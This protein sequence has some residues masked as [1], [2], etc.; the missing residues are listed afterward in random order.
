MS[1]QDN[2][3][4]DYEKINDQLERLDSEI[5]QP[6]QFNASKKSFFNVKKLIVM[7]FLAITIGSVF[8]FNSSSSSSSIGG[9]SGKKNVTGKFMT[10]VP[11]DESKPICPI[12]SKVA[13]KEK[14]QVQFILYDEKY[15]EGVIER[16]SKSLQ[17]DT[18]VYDKT[19][20]YSKM[21]K[22]HEF[23]EGA[24]PLIYKTAEVFKVNSYG[25]VFHFPGSNADLKPV[26]IA[27]HM[28]TVPIGDPHDWNEDP[29]S[30]RFDGDKFHGRGASDCKNLLIGIMEA[31]EKLIQDG[32][33]NFERGV[34]LAFGFDEE[35]SGFDGAFH[36]GEFLVN[37]FGENSVEVITDEGPVMFIDTLGDYYSMIVNGE[38]GYAD[39]EVEITTPGGHSSNPRDH[40][41]IG[42]ISKFL[43]D[44]EDDLYKPVLSD[45]SPMVGFFECLGEHGRLPTDLKNAARRVRYDED[46][47]DYVLDYTNNLPVIKYSIRTAQAID[48]VN[49]GDKANALPRLVNAVINH[50]IAYG[51]DLDTIW[52]KLTKHGKVSADKYDIGL[53]VNGKEI[54]PENENG[55][56]IIRYYADPLVDAPVSSSEDDFYK[57]FTG[58]IKSFYEDEVF[59]EKFNKDSD[60]KFIITPSI[61]SGNTDTR[62]YWKLTDRI[63]RVQ[64]GS[65]NIFDANI[66]GPNEWTDLTTHMQTVSF[67]YNYIS[68]YCLPDEE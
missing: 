7:V 28:D 33:D 27:A 23:L 42:M 60:K 61:M 17:I 66:H 21:A 6:V 54:Y 25:L 47:R 43:T 3:N 15:H 10:P 49:G 29:F 45:D 32:K 8:H 63:Y 46:A 40:T 1:Y 56:M 13:I 2:N 50:R 19:T 20:D 44:Y 58:I 57:E 9:C 55:N 11:F 39:I 14:D 16:F 48:I 68:H 41:S 34:I 26:M 4:S 36:I 22:F 38:K 53:T 5:G 65:L 64:P 18:V 35:K 51:N 24:Y 12:P 37:K 31:T 52:E 30:G 59:P 67:Y 62:H